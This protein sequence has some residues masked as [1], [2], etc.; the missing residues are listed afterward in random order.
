[1][2]NFQASRYMPTGFDDAAY[3]LS[4]FPDNGRFVCLYGGGPGGVP[5]KHLDARQFV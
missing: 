2:A 3:R 5:L 1:M 4:L